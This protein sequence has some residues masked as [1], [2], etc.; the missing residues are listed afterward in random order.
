MPINVAIK[1]EVL[2]GTCTGTCVHRRKLP[3]RYFVGT[4][5]GSLLTKII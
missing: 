4:L 3:I 1:V 5:T 2:L